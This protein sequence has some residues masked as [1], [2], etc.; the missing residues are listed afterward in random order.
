VWQV[1]RPLFSP[2]NPRI[3]ETREK[4]KV[5]EKVLLC[6][7]DSNLRK[8]GFKEEELGGGHS[9]FLLSNENERKTYV[10]LFCFL[11]AAL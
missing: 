1:T 2:L 4:E 8:V 5:K 11:L 3:P 7:A 6:Q 9:L 10:M